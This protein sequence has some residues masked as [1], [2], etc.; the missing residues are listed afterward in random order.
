LADT[1]EDRP[2]EAASASLER[3]RLKGSIKVDGRH[4]PASARRVT[5]RH[6]KVTLTVMDLTSTDILFGLGSVAAAVV[7]ASAVYW[8][9]GRMTRPT[10]APGPI[11]VS[12]APAGPP[13]PAAPTPAAGSPSAP[14]PRTAPAAD[15][16]GRHRAPEELLRASTYRLSADRIARATVQAP[17]RHAQSSQ[18]I[19]S[20]SRSRS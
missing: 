16:H 15:P 18:A 13:G 3:I 17:D 10:A 5:V 6:W 11:P 14:Q 2:I 4:A 7:V 1:A 9:S 20:P 12:P 8:F 19:P